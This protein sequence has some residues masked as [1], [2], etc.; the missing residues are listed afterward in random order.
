MGRLFCGRNLAR[1]PLGYMHPLMW[2]YIAGTSLAYGLIAAPLW[3]IMRLTGQASVQFAQR[4]GH[5]PVRPSTGTDRLW[6]QAVSVGEVRLAVDL[7]RR[8]LQVRPSVE[9]VLSVGT[10]NGYREARRLAGEM[11]EVVYFP[12][13]CLPAARQALKRV[14]PKAVVIFETELWPLFLQTAQDMGI[15]LGLV[16]GR[17]SERTALFYRYLRP[18]FRQ[19]MAGFDWAGAISEADAARLAG[20]GIPA[21]RLIVTGNAKSGLGLNGADRAK[22]EEL[23][24]LLGLENR[25]VLVAGSIRGGEL[26]ELIPAFKGILGQVPE[27]V[28]VLAPRHLVRLSQIQR[29]LSKAGLDHQLR[30]S[31]GPG[32]PRRARL[33]IL[34]TMGELMSVYSTAR[35]AFVG[36]SLS[37]QGGQNPLEPAWWG[38]PVLFGPHMDDFKEPAQR[39]IQADGAKVVHNGRQLALEAKALLTETALRDKM[40]LAAKKVAL[41]PGPA[42]ERSLEVMLRVIDG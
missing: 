25:P 17:I 38:V 30:S 10:P 32:N 22:A 4:L 20:L 39:L 19:T 23:S 40:G 29:A 42:A 5:Y 7:L 13:D 26:D 3:G 18:L 36:A 27:A 15:R 6:L 41:S 8:L 11:A 37:R 2:P 24:H 9:V 16:N 33:V 14:R 28:V 34:D 21:E 12:V 35:A 1:G 31:I